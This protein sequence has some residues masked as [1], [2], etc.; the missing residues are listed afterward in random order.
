MVLVHHFFTR[1]SLFFSETLTFTYR[2]VVCEHLRTIPRI[3]L[4]ASIIAYV[5][6]AESLCG[7]A[8]SESETGSP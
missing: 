8:E 2:G 3:A 7:V 5:E 4:R 1:T 6:Q